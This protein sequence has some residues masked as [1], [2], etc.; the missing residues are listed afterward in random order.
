MKVTRIALLLASA[1]LAS[2]QVYTPPPSKPASANDGGGDTVI[3]RQPEQKNNGPVMGN[4]MPFMDPSSELISWNGHSWAATDNRLLSARFERY[5][6]E[7]ED[8][9]EA[10]T[11]YRETI[12]EILSLISPHHP[13]GPDFAA[14]VQLLPRASSFPGDARLCDSLSQAIYATVLAKKDV[15]ATRALNKAMESEKKRLIDDADWKARHESDPTLGQAEQTGK[16]DGKGKGKQPATNPGRGMVSLDYQEHLRRIAEIEALKKTN[17]VKNE[18]QLVQAKVQYQALMIQFFVQR[19]F[20]H[21]LMASRFYHQIFNDGDNRLHID[22]KSDVSKMISD[23]FGTSPTVAAVDSLANEAIR[24]VDKGVEAFLFLSERGELQSASK[25][26]SESYMVGEFMPAIQTLPREKKRR[27]LEFVRESYK[28]IA[29]IDSKDYTAA[30]GL[31]E[32]LKKTASDFDATKAEAAIATYTRVGN[33]HIDSAKLAAASGDNEK[34]AAEIQKA[35]EV[36]PQNPKLAEFDHLVSQGSGLVIA[37]N[38]FDRL[39]AENNYREIFKRQY[40]LAPAI[41]DDPS[42]EDAFKQ[43]IS[44]IFRIDGA[45]EKASEFRKMGQ[46][47]AAWEQLAL[48]REEFP[49]DPKLGRELELLAPQVADFTLALNKAKTFDQR[50]DRQIGS[51]LS[52]YLKA[53]S[54]YPRSEMAMEGIDR[55]AKEI[56]PDELNEPS[57]RSSAGAEDAYDN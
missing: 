25:R 1:S 21:V 4:E 3:H 55:L 40:E 36:W 17:T 13:G 20:Q 30:E 27:V 32:S 12:D 48:L 52:W 31:V 26:L 49:D 54:I 24:D 47:Y 50:R 41:R 16:G 38:D 28:L 14:A 2:A 6:N 53:R 43:I 15:N 42:R 56:V 8:N 7:P 19:R 18:V 23:T 44:N 46:S 9:S 10:A 57:G 37:K 39:L 5:L 34:A 51:A 11:A 33:M 29:A 35:M 22:K 45:L